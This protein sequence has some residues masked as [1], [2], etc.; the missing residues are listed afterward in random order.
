MVALKNF[1]GKKYIVENMK[2]NQNINTYG[3]KEIR[4]PENYLM[5]KRIELAKIKYEK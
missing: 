3:R 5:R 2:N 4:L 1:D